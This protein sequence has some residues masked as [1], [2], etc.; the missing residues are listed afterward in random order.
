MEEHINDLKYKLRNHEK[1]H[2]EL[3]QL[4]I[5]I[6]KVK[7]DL[8]RWDQVAKHF[9][10]SQDKYSPDVLKSKFDEILAKDLDILDESATAKSEKAVIDSQNEE[11]KTENELLKKQVDDLQR[12]MKQHQTILARLQKK[13]QLVVRE[14]DAYKQLLDNYEKDLTISATSGNN[15]ES[16]L[17]FKIESLEKSITGYKDLCEKMEKELEMAKASPDFA[18]ISLMTNP[19]YES[20]KAET[21]S[22]RMENDRLRRRKDELELE[23]QTAQLRASVYS[24]GRIVHMENN[25]ADAA[26]KMHTVQVEKLQAEIE[27]LRNKC[28]KLEA[29]N[30]ELTMQLQ[31]QSM[32]AANIKEKEDL[33]KKIHSLEAKNMH[34]KEI[35]KSMSQEFREVCYMLF[36]YRVDRVGKASYRI[37]SM[38]ADSA[39][40]YLNFRLNEEGALDMLETEYSE[41]LAD[42]MKTHLQNHNSLPAFL[43]SLTLELFNRTTMCM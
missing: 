40:D 11:I 1:E 29:G 21:N 33:S 37:S 31:D 4:R 30:L 42:M 17:R 36:G 38:Y 43:S 41:S 32:V 18:T 13:L 20:L 6:A 10:P 5:D 8:N 22:L 16:N 24:G 15:Q 28:K 14:R 3:V 2:Q 25:P 35:Y 19:H 23:L 9:L 34:L 26:R 27:I 39:D 7:E 12:G